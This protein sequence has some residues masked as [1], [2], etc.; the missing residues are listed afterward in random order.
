MLAHAGTP[1]RITGTAIRKVFIFICQAI[2]RINLMCS[3]LLTM[4]AILLYLSDLG[5]PVAGG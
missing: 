2:G 5:G 4:D 1:V 3:R